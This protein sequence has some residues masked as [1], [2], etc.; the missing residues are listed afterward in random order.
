LYLRLLHCRQTT[1]ATSY[2][3]LHKVLLKQVSNNKLI[4]KKIKCPSKVS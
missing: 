1:I 2:K 4:D 3:E